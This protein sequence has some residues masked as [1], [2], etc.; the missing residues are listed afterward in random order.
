MNGLTV[1]INVPRGRPRS[2]P[3]LDTHPL[4]RLRI[5]VKITGNHSQSPTSMILGNYQF[6][7]LIIG[8]RRLQRTRGR[9]LTITPLR[10]NFGTTTGRLLKKGTM[11]LLRPKTRRFRATT[12]SGRKL[13]IIQSRMV[14]RFRRQLVRRLNRR[15]ANNKVLHH[16]RPIDSSHHGLVNHRTHINNRRRLRRH[17]LP[18][19]RKHLRITFRR[20]NGKLLNLPLE[21]F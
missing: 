13:R 1:T 15:P 14:R 17:L 11:S 18:P 19:N 4:R 9:Q 20:H 10:P 16:H 7:Y 5:T 6:T 3:E 8:R 12:K 21:V 2:N